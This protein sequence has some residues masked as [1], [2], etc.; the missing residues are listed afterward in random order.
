MSKMKD[1]YETLYN[2]DILRNHAEG[3]QDESVRNALLYML[4]TNRP[5]IN[6]YGQ[7]FL[8][9][10]DFDEKESLGEINR[11][12]HGEDAFAIF[13][14]QITELKSISRQQVTQLTMKM[15][16]AYAVTLMETCLADMLKH[17]VISVPEFMGNAL[18]KISDFQSVKINLLDIYRNPDFITG[19]VMKVLT[20]FL[21]HKIP[22]VLTIYRFT[23]GNDYPEFIKEKT[24]ELV[25]IADIRHDIVHRN[26]YDKEG[27]VHTFNA[28][29]VNKALQDISDFVQGMQ[30]Y[31]QQSVPERP[32]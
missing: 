9:F 25:K 19:F 29:M 14:E 5:E 16:F 7:S 21:Y 31:I 27:N 23:L 12:K 17:A 24:G 22:Q 18:N 3:V 8:T 2:H 20:E 32:F 28:Q 11:L 15:N 13:S 26:G 10:E 6:E 1:V 4:N 30:M